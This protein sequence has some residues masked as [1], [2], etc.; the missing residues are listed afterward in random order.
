[1]RIQMSK[2]CAWRAIYVY[3]GLDNRAMRFSIGIDP[4]YRHDRARIFCSVGWRRDCAGGRTATWLWGFLTWRARFWWRL[5]GR[6]A[7]PFC[8]TGIWR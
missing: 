3:G 8:P 4:T 7:Q 1:M 5:D 2:G 6:R